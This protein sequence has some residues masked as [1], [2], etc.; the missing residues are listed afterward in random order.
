MINITGMKKE[1]VLLALYRAAKP[2]GIG[3]LFTQTEMPLSAAAELV[4]NNPSLYFDYVNGRPLKVDLSGDEFDPYLYDRDNGEGVAQEACARYKSFI[5][6]RLMAEDLE[7]DKINERLLS[8][9]LD[10]YDQ[11]LT[12]R[13]NLPTLV[14][15]GEGAKI[16]SIP[17]NPTKQ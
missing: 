13:F 16:T 9:K 14:D 3:E 10:D 6:H 15:L 7:G 8:S 1:Y 12:E 11:V 17:T 2:K 4:K 5:K